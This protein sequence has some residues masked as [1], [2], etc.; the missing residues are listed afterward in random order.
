MR[1]GGILGVLLAVAAAGL[2]PA[3]ASAQFFD[4]DPGRRRSP[5]SPE[6]FA[7][8]LRV[9]P[10]VPDGG[11]YAQ[12]FADTFGGD[13]GL[14]LAFEYDIYAWR[15]PV[16]GLIGGAFGF[17]WAGY[18]GQAFVA[19]GMR[20]DETTRLDLF[21]LPGLAVLRVDVLARE[22]RI[23][24]VFV[25]KLGVDFIPWST[26]TG[27]TD[28]ASGIAFGLHWAIQV[29]LELDFLDRARARSLDEE[30]GINHTNLFFELQGSTA[31]GALAGA[32]LPVGDPFTWAAG[33]SFVF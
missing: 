15:I 11:A 19:G 20:A 29:A 9:G 33:L 17:G 24:F 32:G 6:T 3:A 18:D 25:G 5:G 13:D 16:V 14:L 10:Y 7:L 23:P 31:S 27:D 26:G 8:E 30:W 12:R 2:G 1:G 4:H 22:L 21:T 28:D